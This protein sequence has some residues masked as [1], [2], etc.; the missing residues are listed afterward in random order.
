M[1]G[2]WYNEARWTQYQDYKDYKDNK[3]VHFNLVVDKD[4]MVG[5]SGTFGFQRKN[6]GCKAGQDESL[7][8]MEIKI[9]ILENALPDSKPE[10]KVLIDK[11]SGKLVKHTSNKTEQIESKCSECDIL[12][13]NNMVLQSHMDTTQ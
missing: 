10:N 1:D 6:A 2:L 13:E 7:N 8:P 9:K 4:S 12:F 11:L 5:K 3:D